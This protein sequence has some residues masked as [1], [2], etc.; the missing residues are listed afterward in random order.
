MS[1]SADVREWHRIIRASV[2]VTRPNP[3]W[4]ILGPAR[5]S[6]SFWMGPQPRDEHP[7]ALIEFEGPT[8]VAIYVHEKKVQQIVL[9][10]AQV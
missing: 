8:P 10:T 7:S 5:Y 2:P 6:V 9:L 3:E 1:E 4:H